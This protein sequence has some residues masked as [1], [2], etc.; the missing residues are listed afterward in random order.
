MGWQAGDLFNGQ[1][2]EKGSSCS[3]GIFSPIRSLL[4]FY[5]VRV[6]K[7]LVSKLTSGGGVSR[8]GEEAS[9]SQSATSVLPLKWHSGICHFAGGCIF[10]YSN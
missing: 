4:G 3:K 6:I 1:R 9:R 5:G 2:T 10:C 8:Q 7:G